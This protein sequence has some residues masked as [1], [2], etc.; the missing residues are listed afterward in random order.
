MLGKAFEGQPLIKDR[1]VSEIILISMVGAALLTIAVTRGKM[2]DSQQF[3]DEH[4]D[5]A[6]DLS[7]SR[8]HS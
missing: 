8:S 3:V 4:I 2:G 5:T 1:D 7:A 6:L